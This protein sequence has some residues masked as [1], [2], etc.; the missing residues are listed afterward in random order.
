MADTDNNAAAEQAKTQNAKFV[1]QRVYL[2]DVSYEAP[3]VPQVFRLPY[4]PAISFNMNTKTTN[5]E[6]SLYEVILTMTVEV[7]GED[8]KVMYVI[9]VQQAGV[10][11]IEGLEGDQ[12][13]QVLNITCA[14]VLFP[15]G[16]EAIDNL[17]NKGS[18]PSIM[19]S[20]INFE[21]AYAEAMQRAKEQQEQEKS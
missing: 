12:L 3:G 7:K 5:F 2:K 17:A 6:A 18:F 16:R 8:D 21:A 9:E 1:V 13:N 15:Y 11:E 19:L 4:K 10:F 14:N 20:P